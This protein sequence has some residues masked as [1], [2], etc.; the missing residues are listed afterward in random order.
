MI[1]IK[2]NI[3]HYMCK[4]YS[5]EMIK[6]YFRKV[7]EEEKVRNR[8]E[9]EISSMMKLKQKDLIL[10]GLE[11]KKSGFLAKYFN[12]PSVNPGDEVNQ[13][14]FNRKNSMKNTFNQAD[15]SRSQILDISDD[16]GASNQWPSGVH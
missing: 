14:E 12:N 3:S 10:L 6:K 11:N 2:P 13:N 7:R 5:K 4:S 15:Q 8:V 16:F 1:A 9:Q